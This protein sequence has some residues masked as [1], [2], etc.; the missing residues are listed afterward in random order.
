MPALISH[1]YGFRNI[2]FCFGIYTN[3][4]INY[5]IEYSVTSNR[6]FYAVLVALDANHG[7]CGPF[8]R[9]TDIFL[10]S[11]FANILIVIVCIL[12][13]MHPDTDPRFKPIN[14][15]RQYDFM[16]SLSFSHKQKS[17]TRCLSIRFELNK[18]FNTGISPLKEQRVDFLF[19]HQ[20]V[21]NAN[22]SNGI[23]LNKPLSQW[24][25]TIHKKD[26][27]ILSWKINK[28]SFE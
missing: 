6:I 10:F 18:D 28:I 15:T 22:H 7:C 24:Q 20:S 4:P 23:E 13:Q 11:S 26:S 2:L 5:W 17:T 3:Q 27:L 1:R 25:C 9:L 8:V 14:S 12:L 16:S 19:D 21:T